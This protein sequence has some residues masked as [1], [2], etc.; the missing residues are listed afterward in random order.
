MLSG[1]GTIAF[2]THRFTF[3]KIFRPLAAQEEVFVQSAIPIVQSALK[4]F[5]YGSSI[6]ILTTR[7][8]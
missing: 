4:V 1:S 5:H 2:G 8:V 3:D 6:P 7:F